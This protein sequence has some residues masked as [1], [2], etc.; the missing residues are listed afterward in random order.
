MNKRGTIAKTLEN[1]LDFLYPPSCYGCGAPLIANF[2]L[3]YKCNEQLKPTNYSLCAVC[4]QPILPGEISCSVHSEATDEEPVLFVRPIT[5]FNDVVRRCLHGLKYQ[6]RADIGEYLGNI[7]GRLVRD[8][9]L[10]KDFDV[11]VPIPI[12]KVRRRERGYNQSEILGER[13]AHF[14]KIIYRNDIAE[15]VRWTKSQTTLGK[16]ER[17]TNVAGV[18]RIRRPELIR[19]NN[20]LIVDDVVTTGA[21]TKSLAYEL[22]RAGAKK[23]GVICVAKTSFEQAQDIKYKS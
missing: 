11:L 8:D 6:G 5:E 12:H 3:C 15:R 18:F 13:I 20:V 21:T 16:D 1:I 7:L 4:E 17:K 9:P 2:L 23:I 22:R 14:T 19:G 10:F